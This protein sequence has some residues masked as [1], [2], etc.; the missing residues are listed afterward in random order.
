LKNAYKEMR[1][2]KQYL[3]LCLLFILIYKALCGYKLFAEKKS[4]TSSEK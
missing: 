1:V 2:S 4:R 3:I